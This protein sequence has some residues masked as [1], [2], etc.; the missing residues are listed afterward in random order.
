VCV[1]AQKLLPACQSDAGNPAPV[2]GSG[3]SVP[4]QFA[5]PD[6]ER[7]R[8][9]LGS[10]EMISSI[11]V[12]RPRSWSSLPWYHDR[13]AA[14]LDPHSG[15]AISRH[16]S[17]AWSSPA[18][19]PGGPPRS[20]STEV[21]QP[22]EAQVV[23][24]GEMI[25]MKSASGTMVPIPR[26]SAFCSTA[27]PTSIL[28]QRTVCR[29]RLLSSARG[30]AAGPDDSEE[31]VSHPNFLLLAAKRRA[32][33]PLFILNYA[34]INVLDVL[35]RIPGVDKRGCSARSII[36]CASGSIPAARQPSLLLPADVTPR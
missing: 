3:R 17:A 14:G 16:R 28:R 1:L 31:I 35:S 30:A 22:I 20:S 34:V 15:R 36:Q 29:W 25:C 11:F 2:A 8:R 4:R 6:R 19:Y 13:G 9:E 24:V 18:T 26:R 33:H 12:D 7:N 27:I 23:G 21:A 5:Q 32:D 10:Q